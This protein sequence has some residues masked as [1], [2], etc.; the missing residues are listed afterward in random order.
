MTDERL[1]HEETADDR[2]IGAMMHV[3]RF[4]TPERVDRLAPH[5]VAPGEVFD[6]D[7]GHLLGQRPTFNAPHRPFN[8]RSALAVARSRSDVGRF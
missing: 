1:D 3:Q 4:D 8:G 2:W 6:S 7:E 5:D